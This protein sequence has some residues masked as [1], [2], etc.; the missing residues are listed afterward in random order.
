MGG[1]LESDR[2]WGDGDAKGG[3]LVQRQWVTCVGGTAHALYRPA[4]VG[5]LGSWRKV[6]GKLGCGFFFLPL[7]TKRFQTNI[8]YSCS[9][10][11]EKLKLTHGVLP[12]LEKEIFLHILWKLV[13]LLKP[14]NS[15]VLKYIIANHNMLNI[16]SSSLICMKLLNSQDRSNYYHWDSIY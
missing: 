4:L 13:G 9:A 1:V 8:F 16:F 5:G 2:I 11:S 15:W 14:L 6:P 12:V 10:I 7:R 3:C